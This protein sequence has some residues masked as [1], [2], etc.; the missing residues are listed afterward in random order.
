MLS[1]HRQATRERLWLWLVACKFICS[2][3]TSSLLLGW[4]FSDFSSS[5]PPSPLRCCRC[6]A[7]WNARREIQRQQTKGKTRKILIYQNMNISGTRTS[8]AS[9]KPR[10]TRV[11]E[12]NFQCKFN[13]STNWI[14]LC[15]SFCSFCLLQVSIVCR[16]D[17]RRRCGNWKRWRKLHNCKILL[18]PTRQRW[19]WWW[20]YA[21]LQF[22]HLRLTRL[23]IW[24]EMMKTWRSEMK[25]R[26]KKFESTPA[27]SQFFNFLS[28][29]IYFCSF[30]YQ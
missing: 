29:V 5:R 26:C 9:T 27:I 18:L 16:A 7:L 20:F 13:S 12:C 30:L 23:K 14:S 1:S 3:A 19:R 10:T 4:E 11:S 2:R 8:S 15:V 22:A 6:S 28:F 21:L 24:N 25:R 17:T